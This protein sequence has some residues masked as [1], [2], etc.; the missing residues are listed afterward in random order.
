MKAKFFCMLAAMT[1]AVALTACSSADDETAEP[2]KPET[3]EQKPDTPKGEGDEADPAASFVESG[4]LLDITKNETYQPEEFATALA[5]S[6]ILASYG[7]QIGDVMKLIEPVFKLQVNARVPKMD[8]LFE[9]EVGLDPTG[10]QQWQVESYLFHYKTTTAEGHDTVYLGR[11]TFPNNTVEGVNHEV[12]NLTLHS[13]QATYEA[14][15]LPSKSLS[16]MTLHALANSAVIEPDYD[17]VDGNLMQVIMAYI[18][19]DKISKVGWDCVEAALDVMHQHGVHLAKDGYLNNWGSSLGMPVTMGICTYYED[20]ASDE[21]KKKAPLHETFAGE[22]I[23]QVSQVHFQADGARQM[24]VAKQGK[25]GPSD[26][27][28]LAS[29]EPTTPVFLACSPYD[30]FVSY[31]ALKA[32][33]EELRLNADGTVNPLVHWIDVPVA[34][35]SMSPKVGG[36][37]FVAATL[38]L[39]YMSCADDPHDMVELLKNSN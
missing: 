32:Y 19:G 2:Q 33:Y 6:P 34:K 18:N 28:Y 35:S 27:T 1:A 22:G 23:T 20:K 39:L 12:K 16:M 14:A 31:D 15:W 7:D 25:L 13:H 37:H 5:N 29:W 8:D 24:K 30:N 4:L 38:V 3:P 36:T 17:E 26:Y 9:D 10:Q 11:V 21:L